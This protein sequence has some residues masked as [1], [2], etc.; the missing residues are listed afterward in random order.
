MRQDDEDDVE[1]GDSLARAVVLGALV[2]AAG[3]VWGA[4]ELIRWWNG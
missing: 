3:A 1:E 4:Y 2:A